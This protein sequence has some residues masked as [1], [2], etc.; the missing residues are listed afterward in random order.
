M[1]TKTLEVVHVPRNVSQ[2]RIQDTRAGS[3]SFPMNR[4]RVSNASRVNLGQ[5]KVTSIRSNLVYKWF[6]I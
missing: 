2:S 5:A 4:H 3:W 1:D 6:T